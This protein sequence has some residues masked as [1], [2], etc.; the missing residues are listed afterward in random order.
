MS[1]RDASGSAP[2]HSHPHNNTMSRNEKFWVDQVTVPQPP[3]PPGERQGV[4]NDTGGR[5]PEQGHGRCARLAMT[6]SCCAPAP[7]HPPSPLHTGR[8]LLVA[9]LLTGWTQ[10]PEVAGQHVAGRAF[11]SMNSSKAL[12][13]AEVHA[14]GAAV[15]CPAMCSGPRQMILSS[16]RG[17]R[18]GQCQYH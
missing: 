16:S 15:T 6:L 4:G 2:Q 9:G 14:A 5:V 1:A 8:S 7:A 18:W 3:P 12:W 11:Q 10:E 17:H 13:S